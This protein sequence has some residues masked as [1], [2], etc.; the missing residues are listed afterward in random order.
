MKLLRT[1]AFQTAVSDNK[2]QREENQRL[3]Q[4]ENSID[5][6]INSATRIRTRSDAVTSNG[7][8]ARASRPKGCSPTTATPGQHRRAWR[9]P[10]RFAGGPGAAGRRQ[11]GMEAACAGLNRTTQS[12]AEDATGRG[13]AGGMASPRASAPAQSTLETGGN[14]GE[15]RAHASR[16]SRPQRPSPCRPTPRSWGSV[17][18]AAL[19][20]IADRRHRERSISLQGAGRAGQPHR[21]RHRHFP[22]AG[23]VFSGTASRATGRFRACAARCAASRSCSTTARSAR[24]PDREGNQQNNQQRDGRLDQRPARHSL[25]QRRAAQQPNSTSARR[26]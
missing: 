12:K 18:M 22:V 14:R 10:C 1:E 8:P 17:A 7:Q 3:R 5:Q 20:I 15:R 16:A 9:R 6:R 11:A 4:R 26:P 2:S 23:A 19:I 25:R 21:E 24:S 13:A